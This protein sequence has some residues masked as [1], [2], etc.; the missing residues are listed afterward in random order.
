M[1]EKPEAQRETQSRSAMFGKMVCGDMAVSQPSDLMGE[2]REQISEVGKFMVIESWEQAHEAREQLA[3]IRAGALS[4]AALLEGLAQLVKS[5]ETMDVEATEEEDPVTEWLIH[6]LKDIIQG[7]PGKGRILE[8]LRNLLKE[9]GEWE[10][11]ET[12]QRGRSAGAGSASRRTGRSKSRSRSRP[13]EITFDK[14]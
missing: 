6:K 9:A 5:A 2:V 11:P 13:R 10:Q 3:E 4:G 14:G 8:G 7:R 1:K 12:Q